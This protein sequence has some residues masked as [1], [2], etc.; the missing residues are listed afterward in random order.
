M[1]YSCELDKIKKI[2]HMVQ[3]NSKKVAELYDNNINDS[4]LT[5]DL[6]ILPNMQKLCYALLSHKLLQ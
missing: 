6:Q 3:E 2:N 4:L 1:S 5:A